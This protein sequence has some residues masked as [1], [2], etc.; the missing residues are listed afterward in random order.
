MKITFACTVPKKSVILLSFAGLELPI[1][2][3][4]T[5]RFA[6]LRNEKRRVKGVKPRRS[7]VNRLYTAS[8]PAGLFSKD[9]RL[10]LGLEP[11]SH[12]FLD[13]QSFRNLLA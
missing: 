13:T 10:P 2:S 4:L 7:L 12:F 11:A 3:D 8:P 6:K 1:F 5:N 9:S